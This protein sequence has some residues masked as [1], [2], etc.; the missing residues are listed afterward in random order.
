MACRFP[1]ARDPEAFWRNRIERRESVRDLTRRRARRRRRLAFRAQPPRLRRRRRAARGFRSLRPRVLRHQRTAKP[2]SWTPQHRQFLTCSYE[3]CERA[4]YDPSCFDVQVGVFG[5][6]GVQPL[7]APQRPHASVAGRIARLLPP[8]ATR[9][10][11]GRPLDLRVV[12]ARS[13]RPAINVQTAC[14]TSLVAIHLAAQALS[15]GECDI[16]LAAAAR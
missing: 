7:P 2:R 5:G 4:G 8:G 12:Q 3:A 9:Q 13:D 14:S 15:A 1:E 16:A 6:S 10:R 11:Q